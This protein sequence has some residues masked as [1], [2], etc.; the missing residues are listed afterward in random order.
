MSL[1]PGGHFFL[2]TCGLQPIFG[3]IGL[4]YEGRSCVALPQSSQQRIGDFYVEIVLPALAGRLDS[5]FPEFGWR[6]DA[7]GWVATNEEMTHRVL[8]VRADRVVA[9]GP[10]PRGFLIHG[11]DP[12][13]WT[14]YVNGGSKARGTDFARAGT[15]LAERAGID[16]A[17]VAGGT[18]DRR[19]DLLQEFFALAQQ[20][21]SSPRG[22]VARE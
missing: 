10:A 6:Q 16:A 5:A 15:Q 17:P 19:A 18:R 1:G 3:T 21:L 11:S 20:E 4:A 9:H 8:G 22:Q 13:L 12:I 14:T 2:P 7:R